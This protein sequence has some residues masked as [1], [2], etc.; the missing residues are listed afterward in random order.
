[1]S[2]R[3]NKTSR[4]GRGRGGRAAGNRK[5]NQSGKA[6]KKTIDREIDRQI[7]AKYIDAITT[8]PTAVTT[9][10]V[11]GAL[12]NVAQGTQD[13]QR[14]GDAIRVMTLTIGTLQAYAYNS[15]VISHMRMIIF[16]WI[17]NIADAAPTIADILE[18][19]TTNSCFSLLNVEHSPEYV[20][21]YDHLFSFAGTST[22]PTDKSDHVIKNKRVKRPPK[23]IVYEATSSSGSAGTV[24]LLLISDSS[25]SPNPAINYSFRVWYKDTTSVGAS[26]K[27]KMVA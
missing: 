18:T 16:Q 23:S 19:P 27:R 20:I 9:S 26:G 21:L 5:V 8:S 6:L 4:T 13:G 12:F 15:D 3:T 24:C 25:A 11:I 17:P 22:V 1:M 14:I 7:Q 10:G 2:Q